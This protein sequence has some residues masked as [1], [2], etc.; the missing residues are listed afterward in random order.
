MALDRYLV[1]GVNLSTEY[2][3]DFISGFLRFCLDKQ[4]KMWYHTFV[5][6]LGGIS[7]R[8]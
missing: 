1:S 2:K 4:K 8:S 5:P 3:A 7:K 6:N